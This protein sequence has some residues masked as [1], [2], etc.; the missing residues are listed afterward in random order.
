MER[1]W[2][3]CSFLLTLVEK[4]TLRVISLIYEV[5]QP[6]FTS[7]LECVNFYLFWETLLDS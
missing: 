6:E 1:T 3:L 4:I 2:N 5:Y 7:Q